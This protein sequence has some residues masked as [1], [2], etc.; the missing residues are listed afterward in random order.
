[1]QT[2]VPQSQTGSS[3]AQETVAWLVMALVKLA[4]WFVTALALSLGAPFWFDTLSK[5]INIR[6]TGVKPD[7]ADAK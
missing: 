7:R 1:V 6:G 3:K 5:F 2:P 4:G